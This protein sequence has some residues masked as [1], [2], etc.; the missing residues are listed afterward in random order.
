MASAFVG[1]NQ[2]LFCEMDPSLGRQGAG[3]LR[4]V[5][6][7]QDVGRNLRGEETGTWKH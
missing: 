7:I 4:G 1:R 2:L 6:P 5:S 3:A